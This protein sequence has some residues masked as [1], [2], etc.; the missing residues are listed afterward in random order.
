MYTIRRGYRWVLMC[1]ALATLSCAARAASPVGHEAKLPGATGMDNTRLI[2][3]PMG[4]LVAL[5]SDPVPGFARYTADGR[6]RGEPVVLP[7]RADAS[8]GIIVDAA[9]CGTGQFLLEW[10]SQDGSYNTLE[11]NVQRFGI[12]GKPLGGIFH[13]APSRPWASLACDAQGDFIAAWDETDGDLQT[14]YARRYASTGAAVGDKFEISTSVQ[15]SDFSP[16][17]AVDGDGDAVVTWTHGSYPQYR[18]FARRVPKDALPAAPPFQ[19]DTLST[20]ASESAYPLRIVM[21]A[22]GDYAVLH[23]T[24]HQNDSFLDSVRLRWF[25]AKDRPVGEET[26]L[27]Y[28]Y[29]T[30]VAM[31]A[32]GNLA[33]AGFVVSANPTYH[34]VA[35][36][37]FDVTGRPVGETLAAEEK[38]DT[39]LRMT[40]AAMDADGDFVVGWWNASPYGLDTKGLSFRRFR[41][42]RPVDVGVQLNRE[43]DSI[44]S[45]GSAQF[46]A[47][48][49]NHAPVAEPTHF[50]SL[51]RGANAAAATAV[52]LTIAGPG[53]FTEV[54]T[55]SP[56][57][58]CAIVDSSRARCLFD[59]SLHAS[60]SAPP[61]DVSVDALDTAGT[62][63][64]SAVVDSQPLD[65]SPDNDVATQAVDVVCAAGEVGFLPSLRYVGEQAGQVTVYVGRRGSACR[66]VDVAL[67]TVSGTATRGTDFTG[68]TQTLHWAAGDVSTREIAIPIADDALDESKERFDVVLGT[69]VGADLSGNGV[70]TLS[71]EDNDPTP[72][73]RFTA[74]QQGLAEGSTGEVA[75]A[76]GAV[77]G[78]DVTI[79][80]ELAG[81]AV[82]GRDYAM[83][84]TTFRIP[85]GHLGAT[86]PI[87]AKADTR[88][89]SDESIVLT[90]T[91]AANARIGRPS[92][93]TIVIPG[94]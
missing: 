93:Q 76:L 49:S 19:V 9:M 24:Y 2:M 38:Q 92:T 94:H 91:N 34:D 61:I 74:G 83:K 8:R 27:P 25:D 3:D 15:D 60:T 77:S 42:D 88:T 52:D 16:L 86:L 75:V 66:A 45:L 44:D 7:I 43:R 82:R 5:W 1:I 89:E 31:D 40:D 73:V 14:V 84:R 12:D 23:Y 53:A 59:S 51:D 30:R 26:K 81:D 37:L 48:V 68:V 39:Y 57:V 85:A 67:S 20:R 63:E 10:G 6:P 22:R 50:A 55:S 28:S 62:I 90:L 41:S 78:K 54:P 65:P 47:V 35:V 32:A 79:E 18:T 29:G 58:T 33:L 13:V 4:N 11:M 70:A 71:I 21:D 64:L 36:Q 72:L 46:S 17:V 56:H 80:V 87:E 69:P